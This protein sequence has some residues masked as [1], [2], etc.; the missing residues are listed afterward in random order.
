MTNLK[1]KANSSMQIS[2]TTLFGCDFGDCLC[3][4][5][6]GIYGIQDVRINSGLVI[7]KGCPFR[8]DFV[9]VRRKKV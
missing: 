4:F 8:K 6:R 1:K 7:T 9:D 2:R 3:R 5:F